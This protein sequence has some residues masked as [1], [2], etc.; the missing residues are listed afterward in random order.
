MYQ[1]AEI[2]GFLRTVAI[3]LIVIHFLRIIGRM[4]APWLAKKATSRMQKMA[5]ER[6]RQRGFTNST[7]HQKPEG[8]VTVEKTS[9]ASKKK[10]KS[11]DSD[12]VDY[13]IIE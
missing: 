1:T 10:G 7:N 11:A 9:A 4:L 5:E 2:W 3:I 6:M 12:Y 13:E 8:T